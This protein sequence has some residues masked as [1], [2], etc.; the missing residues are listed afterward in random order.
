MKIT[1]IS[2]AVKTPGRYNIFVDEKY[3]FSLDELQLLKLGLRKGQEIDE[4]EHENLKGESDFG[5][6]YIRAIDLISRRLRS[7]REIRDYAF[8]KQWTKQ[9]LERVIER[10]HEKDYLND[11]RFAEM[12]VRSRG[13]TKAT[14]KRKLM[15]ELRKKGVSTNIIDDVLRDNDDYDE[16]DALRKMIAKKSGRYE[17]EQKLVEYLARQGYRYDD[18][19]KALSGDEDH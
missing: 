11:K 12:W 2:P 3:S 8:R 18:I 14:S 6:N 16:M 19:K 15:L 13:A 7:E 10:L 1:K 5:K 17:T 4:A 9:N